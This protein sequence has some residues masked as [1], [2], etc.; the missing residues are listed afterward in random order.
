MSAASSLSVN[1]TLM[2]EVKVL[3]LF[4]PRE[5]SLQEKR[6][7]GFNVSFFIRGMIGN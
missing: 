5:I 4:L 3:R 7:F 1:F 6:D 2:P